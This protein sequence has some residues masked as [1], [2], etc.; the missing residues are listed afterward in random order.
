MI[1]IGFLMGNKDMGDSILHVM[2]FHYFIN[3]F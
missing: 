3:P 1:R 2:A